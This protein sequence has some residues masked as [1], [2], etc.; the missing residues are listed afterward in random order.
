[1]TTY[2]YPNPEMEVR[3]AGPVPVWPWVEEYN[4]EFRGSELHR[5]RQRVIEQILLHRNPQCTPIV[6]QK[7][8][9]LVAG[10]FDSMMKDIG[11]EEE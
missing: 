2:L 4:I 9:E 1:M 3:T 5:L 7:F 6:M 11:L 8:K 10:L